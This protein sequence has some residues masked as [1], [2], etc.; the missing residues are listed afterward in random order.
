MRPFYRFFL[1]LYALLFAVT[2]LVISLVVLG[3]AGSASQ[4][5]ASPSGVFIRLLGWEIPFSLLE[6]FFWSNPLY[7]WLVIILG[8]ILFLLGIYVVI[9]SFLGGGK[10]TSFLVTQ[11]EIGEVT[12]TRTTLEGIILAF[13]RKNEN[14]EEAR[15]ALRNTKE[16]VV[17]FL[18]V[19]LKEGVSFPEIASSLQEALKNEIETKTGVKV[20]EVKIT[21]DNSLVKSQRPK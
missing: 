10:E 11:G 12:V 21:V 8:I 4:I 19:A 6:N 18:A 15:T 14:I 5:L 1:T 7:Y 3:L 16:G 9:G 17:V 13:A 20:K 2:S